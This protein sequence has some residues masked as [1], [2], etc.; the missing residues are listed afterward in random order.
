MIYNIST[1][2]ERNLLK[3]QNK[4]DKLNSLLIQNKDKIEFLLNDKQIS[5]QEFDQ[6]IKIAEQDFSQNYAKKL[7]SYMQRQKI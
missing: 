4:I 6:Q 3:N 2:R 7:M 1:I 5:Q